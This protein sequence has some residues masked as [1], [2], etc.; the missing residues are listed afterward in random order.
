[1]PNF[2]GSTV[3][4][5]RVMGSEYKGS[6]FGALF[7]LAGAVRD[8]TQGGGKPH[9]LFERSQAPAP[10]QIMLQLHFP[11][12]IPTWQRYESLRLPLGRTVRH[13]GPMM[14]LAEHIALER[15]NKACALL[16]LGSSVRPKPEAEGKAMQ[17]LLR[18][19]AVEMALFLV[20]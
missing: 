10:W 9:F 6:D 19:C 4:L 13:F 5:H 16:L 14:L 3:I 12:L 8:L 15:P 11:R 2:P 20:S 17:R 1:M 18:R 7:R